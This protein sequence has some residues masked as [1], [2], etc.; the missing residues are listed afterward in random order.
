MAKEKPPLTV[1]GDVGGRIAIMVDDMI[2]E[3]DSF[4]ACAEVLKERGAYKVYVVVTH[5]LLS[6]DAPQILEKSPID[7]VIK[8]DLS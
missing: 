1:V 4:V 6:A 2:D 5:G 7:E 8:T 3:V